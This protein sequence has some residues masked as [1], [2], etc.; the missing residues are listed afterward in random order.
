MPRK[1]H[2][3]VYNNFLVSYFPGDLNSLAHKI[4]NRYRFGHK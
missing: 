4:T 3:F 2:Y 1:L